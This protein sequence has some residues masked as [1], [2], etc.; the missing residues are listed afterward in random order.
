M[1]ERESTVSSIY[2]KL[3]NDDNIVLQIPE[4]N[5][6]VAYFIIDDIKYSAWWSEEWGVDKDSIEVVKD[7]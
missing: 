5:Q 3:M 6:G 4:S 7:D 1:K 2:E